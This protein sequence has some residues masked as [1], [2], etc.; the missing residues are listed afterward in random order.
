MSEALADQSLAKRVRVQ[1]GRTLISDGPFA[2]AKESFYLIDCDSIE[3]AIEHA[4]R[5]PEAAA[6]LDLVEVRPVMS[7]N[8]YEM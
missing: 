3:Q 2:E 8:G 4:A 7:L 5:V 1:D 6:G